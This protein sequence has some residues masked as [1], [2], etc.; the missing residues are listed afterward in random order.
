MK[1]R[2]SL[3]G[4]IVLQSFVQRFMILFVNT[5][6]QWTVFLWY[7]FA[8]VILIIVHFMLQQLAEFLLF[9]AV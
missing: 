3:L 6:K 7:L 5:F 9:Y 2:L 1:S 4:M 8:I